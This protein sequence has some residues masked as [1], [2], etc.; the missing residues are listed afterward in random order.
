MHTYHRQSIFLFSQLQIMRLDQFKHDY[1]DSVTDKLNVH[2]C[3]AVI[4]NYSK[5]AENLFTD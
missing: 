4:T 2:I 1:I 5:G 3:Y